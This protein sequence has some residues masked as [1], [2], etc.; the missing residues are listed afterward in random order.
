MDFWPTATLTEIRPTIRLRSSNSKVNENLTLPDADG[1]A[2]HIEPH[3]R[4]ILGPSRPPRTQN[5]NAG[6]V[7]YCALPSQNGNCSS[8]KRPPQS[9][10]GS[11]RQQRPSK[12]K[13]KARANIPRAPLPRPRS[14]ADSEVQ[15]P[16]HGENSYCKYL[17]SFHSKIG[18]R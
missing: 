18:T 2:T 6:R 8:F 12:T 1:P 4:V 10:Q 15:S 9:Q 7:N 17:C 13:E 5:V 14:F 16:R 11:T 3:L